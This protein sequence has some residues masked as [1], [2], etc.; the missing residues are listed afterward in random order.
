MSGQSDE[1]RSSS[2]KGPSP[3]AGLL[4]VLGSFGLFYNFIAFVD[5]LL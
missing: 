4:F 3:A 1:N 2:G 5:P